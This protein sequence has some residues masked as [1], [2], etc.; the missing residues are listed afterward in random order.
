MADERHRS[1]L[2]QRLTAIETTQKLY[3]DEM[4][5]II[6]A[7]H[8]DLTA[9]KE[10]FKHMGRVIY[11]GEAPGILENIRGLMWKFGLVTTLGFGIVA[12]SL[13]LFSPALNK[14]AIKMVG[15]DSLSQLK[16]QSGKKKLKHWNPE[17]GKMEYYI[18]FSPVGVEPSE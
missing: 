3:H 13:K 12:F 17:A 16:Y 1:E 4:K 11:G 7:Q 8:K 5:S 10:D 2:S 18:E 15:A 9:V 6:E 14:M